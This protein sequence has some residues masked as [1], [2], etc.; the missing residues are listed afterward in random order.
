MSSRSKHILLT[1]IFAMMIAILGNGC[2]TALYICAQ[3]SGEAENI[4]RSNVRPWGNILYGDY[5]MLRDIWEGSDDYLLPSWLDRWLNTVC[6]GLDFSISAVF[7]ILTF[8]YQW[9]RYHHLP[10]LPEG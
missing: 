8:P 9:W 1:S 5:V 7:D 3:S 6:L 4:R 2:A 10:P